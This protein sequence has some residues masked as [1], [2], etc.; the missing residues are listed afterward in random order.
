MGPKSA[1]VA[2]IGSWLGLVPKLGADCVQLPV[3]TRGLPLIDKKFIAACH[4][5]SLP[6]H[7]WTINVESEMDR[8]L[9]LGVDGIMTD[10][11]A[12]LAGVFR[13]RGLALNGSIA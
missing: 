4:R 11:P 12:T 7:V 1:A 6:V 13:R 2:R 9:D 3:R 10:H 8:L 5:Q